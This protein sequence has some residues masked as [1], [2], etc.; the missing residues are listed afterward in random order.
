VPFEPVLPD[1]EEMVTMTVPVMV[2]FGRF[3]GLALTFS[4]MPSAGRM[5]LDGSTV[6]HG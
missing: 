6:S 3:A 1:G 2:P 4:V 5:P